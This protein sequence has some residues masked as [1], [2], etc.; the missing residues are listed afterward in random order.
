[1]NNM[2]LFCN[3]QFGTIRTMLI[4]GEPWFVAKDVCE[5]LELD[6]SQVRRLDDDEK[7]LRSIQ[8]LGGFQEMVTINEPGLYSLILGSRKPEARAFK[9]WVTH[10][11]LPAIRRTGAYL[12]P[13]AVTNAMTEL[14]A[15]MD[16]MQD[17]LSDMRRIIPRGG[18]IAKVLTAKANGTLDAEA[19]G[20]K[21]NGAAR[22]LL[23]REKIGKKITVYM[24]E[25]DLSVDEFAE[26][27][28]VDKRSVFR[29]RNGTHA[30]AGHALEKVCE[31]LGCD[32][33]DLL[34]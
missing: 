24:I 1:M 14:Q 9:R 32:V 31:L 11:I 7:G 16:A 27:T 13:G 22:A 21:G 17:M 12:A 15:A 3:D 6:V 19:F 20:R 29:W 18:S 33:A 8:T 25:E 10:E 5:A 34:R 2:Q 23:D 30:P 4:D 28:G 26:M